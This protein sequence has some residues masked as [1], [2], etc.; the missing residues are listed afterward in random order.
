MQTATYWY[1]GICPQTGEQLRLPRTREVEAIAR[2]LIAE[3]AAAPQDKAPYRR[4]GK[5]Y[6]V[7]LAVDAQGHRHILR[8]FSGLLGGESELPGWVP[9]IPGRDRV[10]LQEA[11]TL[12]QLEMLKQQIIALKTIPERSHLAELAPTFEQRLREM[13]DR[14]R[15][16]KQQR[17][18]SREQI[19]SKQDAS[20]TESLAAAQ[21][22]QEALDEQSRR[23][24]IER[25]NLKR[26]RK[27]T[28]GP[29][30]AAIAQADE[31]I[32]ALKRQRR[33]LSRQLQAQMHAAYSIT[34]FGGRSQSL[35]SLMPNGLP[36]GTGDCCAPKL[37]HCAATQGL[38]P[39]AMAEFWW[40]PSE[41]AMAQGETAQGETV[42]GTAQGDKIQG[43]FYGACADR[44]QPL[45]GFLLSGSRAAL[46]PNP[47]P[48]AGRGALNQELDAPFSPTREKGA[49]GM[50]ASDL[51]VLYED[52]H[53][54][55]IDKPAGLLSVPGRTGDRQDSVLSRLRNTHPQG[56]HLTPVHRLD[57]A[58]SGILLLAKDPDTNRYLCEQFEQR[59][60]QKVYEAILG[61]SV[62]LN[63]GEIN[64][65]LWGDPR[66]RPRQSVH[67]E[68]G[69]PSLTRFRV[70][71]REENNKVRIEFFPITGRTHQLRVHAR[72]GLGC[73]ILGDRLYGCTAPVPRL[74]LHAKC[75]SFTHFHTGSRV[76][77]RSQVPF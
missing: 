71:V 61:G 36:T 45:M 23:D 46:T 1:E 39:L 37:L 31:Q 77:L 22:E 42:Q 55:A 9:P 50:R 26:E 48:K 2:S 13:G 21:A 11:K 69:K 25:R 8:A 3:L 65:P 30:Q 60:V 67:W 40:G 44:C 20:A 19:S 18:I 56:A 73:V 74:H 52:D 29:L 28:L 62:L 6:G 76:E 33:E 54:L 7:L 57:Q 17:Q 41:G 47:S 68:L 10:A 35:A 12:A 49:G 51:P 66:D 24:G 64:L 4:E 15:C 75:L 16:N 58:T 38:K 53:L 72:E 34:N 59:Q 43:Q 63:D 14:H 70:L 5:M 32:R 27:Q